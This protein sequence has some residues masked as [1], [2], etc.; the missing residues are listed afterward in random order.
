MSRR[1]HSILLVTSVTA[2]ALAGSLVWQHWTAGPIQQA[3]RQ[4]QEREWLAVLPTGSYDNQPLQA[5]LALADNQLPHSRLLAGYRASLANTPVAIMLRSEVPG[6]AGPIELAIAIDNHGRLTGLRVL[7]QQ[8]SPGLGDQLVDPA[9]HWLD[10]F[11]GKAHDDP[12]EQAWALKRDRGSFDQ[13]AGATV[14]SRAVIDAVQD[15]LRYYD[16]HRTALLGEH[17]HE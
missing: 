14:T 2:L 4:M 9:R 11:I 1:A 6:Y 16:Q 17:K 8:E 5:P 12:P 10:Q 15:A 7:R 13:L 3:Q